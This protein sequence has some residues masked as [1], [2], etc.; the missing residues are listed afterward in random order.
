MNVNQVSLDVVIV[1]WN[2]GD[3]LRRCLCSLTS[4]KQ[5]T[6]KLDQVIVVDNA[7]MDGSADGLEDL[8]LPLCVIRNTCNKGFAAACN[9]GAL[10]SISDYLLFLN[11]DVV[12]CEDSLVTPISFMQQPEHSNIGICGIQLLDLQGVIARSCARFPTPG[13]FYA[14]IF[15]LTSLLPNLFSGHLMTE[16]DHQS[17]RQVDHVIGAFFL[18]RQKL[19]HELGGF[20]ERFFVYLED[21]DFSYRANELGYLSYYLKDAQACHKGGGTSGQIKAERLFYS[22]RSRILYGYKHFPWLSA[23][24]LAFCTL[25][26]EPIIRLVFAISHLSL[27]M[28]I[29]IIAGYL[30]L[31]RDVPRFLFSKP[32][33]VA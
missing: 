11:P 2:S 7:S 29:E 21:I 24:A 13:A 31:W 18:I 10:S 12:L 26:I 28:T 6:F 22:L 14:K 8:N 17:N 25:F 9:Q 32:Q 3:Q 19:F 5:D 4:V 1:N 23:T 20:D 33:P 15:G 16:W 27:H 30:K